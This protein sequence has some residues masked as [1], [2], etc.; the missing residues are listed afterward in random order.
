MKAH[1]PHIQ[2]NEIIVVV[3]KNVVVLQEGNARCER[4]F[5]FAIGDFIAIPQNRGEPLVSRFAK[6]NL[7]TLHD[8]RDFQ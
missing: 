6:M 3:G 7:L 2:S 5:L 8:K 1:C 4:I